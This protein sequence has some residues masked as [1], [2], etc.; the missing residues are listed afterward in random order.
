MDLSMNWIP[1]SFFG[2]PNRSPILISQRKGSWKFCNTNGDRSYY[3]NRKISCDLS[4]WL[5][6][7]QKSEMGAVLCSTMLLLSRLPRAHHLP[8]AAAS[9]SHCSVSKADEEQR[10]ALRHGLKNKKHQQQ[11]NKKKTSPVTMRIVI[12]LCDKSRSLD[13]K[14]SAGRSLSL[15]SWDVTMEANASG[16]WIKRMDFEIPSL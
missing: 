12:K 5:P 4:R 9:G 13:M 10:T 8:Y 1:S 16:L 6:L 2:F 14:L 7:S 11:Y 3:W 15:M